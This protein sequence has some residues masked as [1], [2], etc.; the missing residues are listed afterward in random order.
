[1][2]LIV[3]KLLWNFDL[4]LDPSCSNW[5]EQKIFALWSKPPLQVHI[6]SRFA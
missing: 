2:R 4:A 5:H 1:M 6:K 3:A